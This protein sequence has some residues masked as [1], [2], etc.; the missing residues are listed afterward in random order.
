[1]GMYGHTFGYLMRPLADIAIYL[2]IPP[3]TDAIVVAPEISGLISELDEFKGAWGIGAGTPL[4][5]VQG[6][7][8]RKHWLVDPH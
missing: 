8:G 5:V 6:G 2:G 3:R 7:D 4:S 1:M